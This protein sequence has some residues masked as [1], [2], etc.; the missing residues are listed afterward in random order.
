MFIVCLFYFLDDLGIGNN[1]QMQPYD[2]GYLT[3]NL[4][5]IGKTLFMKFCLFIDAILSICLSVCLSPSP[6]G[7]FIFL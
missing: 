7:T 3:E 6:S 1:S 2:M 5:Y 4:T